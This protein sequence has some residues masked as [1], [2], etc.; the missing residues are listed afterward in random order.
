VRSG[1]SVFITVF[2]PIV[3][4]TLIGL[5][6]AYYNIRRPVPVALGSVLA[7]VC[8]VS[9]DEI[10]AYCDT[11]TPEEDIV[12]HLRREAA[13]NQLAVS[14]RYIDQMTWNTRL[15]Q[16][17]ARFEMLKIDPA[18]SSMQYATSESLTVSLAEEAAKVRWLLVKG[19]VAL[20]VRR[21]P[22]LKVR[23]RAIDKLR[24]LMTEYKQL[25]EDAVALVRIA[26]DD[27]YYSM[28]V[29][30]LGLSGWRL[31]DGGSSAS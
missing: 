8:V 10:F 17:V 13:W 11:S 5:M 22:G 29:E 4:A 15:F 30:R 25:E 27:C 1:I 9:A 7:K 20:A 19:Q 31:I 21:L 6:L 23:T 26:G 18:K 3:I 12:P 2:A 16:Q 24:E 14:R 28:L